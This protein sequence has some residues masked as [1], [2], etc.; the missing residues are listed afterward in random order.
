MVGIAIPVTKSLR[1]LAMLGLFVSALWLPPAALA[2]DQQDKNEAK[3][4]DERLKELE[5]EKQL[6]RLFADT[7]E[8]VKSKYVEADVSDRELIEAAI[9]GMISKLDPYSNYIPPQELD[10]FRKGV[11]REYVGIGIQ[12]SDRDGH[13]QITSPLFGTPAWRAGLRAGDRILR[14]GDTST[15]DLSIDDAIRLMT[16]KEGTEV[17]ISVLHPDETQAETVKLKRERI[18]QP[19]VIGYRRNAQGEWDYV[20]DARHKIAYI[21]I[22][23]FSGNTAKD[24]R[25]TLKSLLELQIQGL[26]IDLRFNPGGMLNQAVAVCDMFLRKGRIVSIEGRAVRHQ[27]WDAKEAGTLIPDGFPVAVLINRYSASAAEIVSACLQDNNVAVVVGERSWGK[28]SVQ[29]IIVLEDGQSALKLTTAGYHRPSGENIHREV[30]ASEEDQWGVHP[31]DGYEVKMSNG[32][33]RDLGLSYAQ[34]DELTRVHHNGDGE[35]A[36]TD[37]EEAADDSGRP[38]QDRQLDKALEAL[39]AQ[40]EPVE[41]AKPAGEEPQQNDA[42][43]QGEVDADSGAR[44]N[45]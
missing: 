31:S 27:T 32:E 20:C 11:E 42:A 25:R 45:L 38:L 5:Q 24:L 8:Q 21:R 30:G 19:T 40:I 29:N 4:A 34:R 22:T 3:S 12:V 43:A 17:T 18:R 35:E 23:A 33:L 28:G 14:I 6:I 9:Q 41:K 1:V 10:E 37:S 7:L 44:N 39:R 26:V 2:A 36:N 15:R 16:G 13:L